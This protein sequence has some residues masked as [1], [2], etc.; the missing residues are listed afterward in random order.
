MH[1][2]VGLAAV[3]GILAAS[4]ADAAAIDLP[5]TA[6]V[7]PESRTVALRLDCEAK[8]GISA[9]LTVPAFAGLPFDFDGLEGPS[10]SA[11]P[12]TDLR[13]VTAAGVRS[14]RTRASGAVAADPATSFT[15]SV[16]PARRGEAPLRDAALGL[17]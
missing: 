16:A 17:A 6:T 9:T 10:G 7:G 2:W 15:L 3:A 4:Q 5:G 13:V 14:T 1:R 8:T 12:L 11:V